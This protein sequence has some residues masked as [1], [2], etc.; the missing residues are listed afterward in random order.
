MNKLINFKSLKEFERKGFVLLNSD[1]VNNTIDNKL[2]DILIAKRITISELS[3]KSGVSKQVISSSIVKNTKIS[4]DSAI[5]I[6]HVLETPL[7]DIFKL[8]S[9]AWIDV[10]LVDGKT[11]Y[12]NMK[13]LRMIDNNEKNEYIKKYG[14]RYYNPVNG[15]VSED[16]INNNYIDL[17]IQV[18]KRIEEI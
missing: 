1:I 4:I 9:N 15:N 11:V 3:R 7:E 13:T 8:K 6:S 5:K 17:F 16:K 14:I 18:G 2:Q 12:L 10:Y